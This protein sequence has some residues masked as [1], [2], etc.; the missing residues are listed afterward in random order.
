MLPPMLHNVRP[1]LSWTPS[2]GQREGENKEKNLPAVLAGK[3][4]GPRVRKSEREA[5]MALGGA[6]PPLPAE[7]WELRG[8]DFI[9]ALALR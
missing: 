4:K 7:L 9:T 3:K 8:P 1:R 2:S 6:P 5:G